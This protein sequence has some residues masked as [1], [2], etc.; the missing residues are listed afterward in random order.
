MKLNLSL[1][2]I[3]FF[4]F[5]SFAQDPKI[6][7]EGKF[8]DTKKYFNLMSEPSVKWEVSN[9]PYTSLIALKG[10]VKSLKVYAEASPILHKA[11][12]SETGFVRSNGKAFQVDQIYKF[13]KNGYKAE[14]SS[15][16][17]EGKGSY[18]YVYEYD[19]QG[20]QVNYKNYSPYNTLVFEQNS[21]YNEFNQI[22]EKEKYENDTLV[23]VFKI[24]Y[25]QVNKIATSYF[26]QT[27]L[28]ITRKSVYEFT[29]DNQRKKLTF[30]DFEGNINR[31]LEY[32][33]N[34]KGLLIKEYFKDISRNNEFTTVL[35]YNK[36]AKLIS[37]VQYDKEN[38]ITS[39]KY[40]EYD[41]K[42]NLVKNASTRQDHE[43]REIIKT[44]EF[45]NWTQ[46][47]IST[48]GFIEYIMH[49]EF[50]YF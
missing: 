36:K 49:R 10:N 45:G 11:S 41:K 30:Y 2:F 12:V 16:L 1:T 17:K 15:I 28:E 26:T 38:E 19:E 39:Q 46:Q 42:G 33:Y 50:E 29:S 9:R 48:L 32:T 8:V 37:E 34:K 13:D 40:I 31:F 22:I 47:S 35:E 4:I 3:L 24:E 14:T 23:S 21:K 27:D 43:V 7:V 6:K 25:D 5:Q 44:D 18:R 20:N